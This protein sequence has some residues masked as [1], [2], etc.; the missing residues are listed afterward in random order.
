[1]R[2]CPRNRFLLLNC[3]AANTTSIFSAS[4]RSRCE[5]NNCTTIWKHKNSAQRHSARISTRCK[6]WSR[7]G[8]TGMFNWTTI[9]PSYSIL[10]TQRSQRPRRLK[11]ICSFRWEA[12]TSPL[13]RIIV[14][15]HII[16]VCTRLTA[17]CK[18]SVNNQMFASRSKPSNRF[19]RRKTN[20]R[21][22]SNQSGWIGTKMKSN[23]KRIL[24]L[25]WPPAATSTT[26]CN[27]PGSTQ[28]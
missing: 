20:S 21:N 19:C 15:W 25:L 18:A 3:K 13:Q 1:M 24:L 16:L 2:R 17:Q 8:A 27:P 7:R 28:T 12:E 9:W 10:D 11:A 4:T 14:L 5:N 26:C 6:K 23:Q 22:R